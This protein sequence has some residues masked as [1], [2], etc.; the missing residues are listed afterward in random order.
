MLKFFLWLR[1]LRKKK[2][3]LLSIVAVALS[4]ALLIVVASIFSG[5]IAAIEKT[6]EEVFGDIYLYAMVPIP[7]HRQLLGR[8]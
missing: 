8:L 3:V 5:F 2:I 1:Y 6:G 4:V 7:E